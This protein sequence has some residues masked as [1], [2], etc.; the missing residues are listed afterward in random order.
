M[1]EAISRVVILSMVNYQLVQTP[2][3]FAYEIS[4]FMLFILF[5]CLFICMEIFASFEL[6]VVSSFK[7]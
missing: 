3:Q 5:I 6:S 4:Y 7:F 1:V 2:W